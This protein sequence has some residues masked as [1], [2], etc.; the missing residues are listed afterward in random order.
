MMP[1]FSIK[2]LHDFFFTLPIFLRK[3]GSEHGERALDLAYGLYS[4]CKHKGLS[5][6][7][8]AYNTLVI[9]W[10]E[11]SKLARTPRKKIE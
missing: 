7:A 1:T 9:A 2:N 10:P 11:I 8:V 3:L 5:S 6:E 4:L